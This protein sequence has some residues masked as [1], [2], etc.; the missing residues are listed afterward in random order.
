[1][2]LPHD[3]HTGLEPSLS[4]ADDARLSG[5]EPLLGGALRHASHRPQIISVHAYRRSTGKSTIAANLASHL[6]A[7][8]R[9]V[10]IVDA[11]FSSP[12]IGI[13]FGF[14]A[15]DEQ[16]TLNDFLLGL[17]GIED[18]AYRVETCLDEL[19]RRYLLGKNLWI[20]PASV[21]FDRMRQLMSHGYEVSGFNKGLQ[22]L[23][24]QLNLDYML[25]DTT[26][27]LADETLLYLAI[28][29][30]TLFCLRPDQQDFQGTA[31]M[32]DVARSLDVVNL[33]LVINM[34]LSRYDPVQ[35]TGQVELAYGTPV[36]GVLPI[37]EDVM[38]S[39]P[40]G[41]FSLMHPE[42]IWSQ[43]IKAIAE[44]LLG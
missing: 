27:G 40:S 23:R 20:V 12:G 44:S 25:I 33:S 39:G 13:L 42:S 14:N 6:A 22:L 24:K 38:D 30:A 41:V 36:T 35:L 15:W 5:L 19:S 28:S 4:G 10:A 17:C 37:S 32:V 43:Q 8:G 3:K 31:V 26:P 7:M 1:M 2:Q 34:A 21:G 9:R 18:V 16:Y 11:N 29:D